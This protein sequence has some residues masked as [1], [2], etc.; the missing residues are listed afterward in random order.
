MKSN[1]KVFTNQFLFFLSIL[2]VMICV[3]QVFAVTIHP[4]SEKGIHFIVKNITY[5]VSSS[6]KFP[7]ITIASSYIVFNTTRFD[8]FSF[9]PVQISLLY[10]HPDIPR[11]RSGEKIVEFNAKANLGLILF[12]LSGLP[13]DASYY[14]KPSMNLFF[15]R[16][17]THQ[18]LLCFLTIVKNTQRFTVFKM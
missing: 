8:V 16:L 4:T 2:F 11:A 18:S 12:T 10:L 6:M 17:L 9:I 5:S 3:L 1:R 14:I 15:Y 7:Q 13:K